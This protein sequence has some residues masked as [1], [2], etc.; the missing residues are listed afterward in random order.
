MYAI[1]SYYEEPQRRIAREIVEDEPP[2]SEPAFSQAV[3]EGILLQANPRN[4]FV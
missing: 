3:A 4:N 1:R 2:T